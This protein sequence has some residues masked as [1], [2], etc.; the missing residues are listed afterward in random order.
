MHCSVG[1]DD[2][3]SCEDCQSNNIRPQTAVVKAK[4][5]E[6]RS[7]GDFDVKTILMV[8]ECQ[9]SYFVHDQG[10]KAV[11]EDGKLVHR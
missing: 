4:G 11:V 5:A 1:D 6:N 8:Y 3:S 2:K 10:F 9:V 7:T